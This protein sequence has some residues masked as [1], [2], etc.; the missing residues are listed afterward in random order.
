MHVKTKTVPGFV[1]EFTRV[2]PIYSDYILVDDL[3]DQTGAYS[4][5]R[6]EWNQDVSVR[7]AKMRY[8]LKGF[9]FFPVKVSLD[10]VISKLPNFLVRPL[11]DVIPIKR[12]LEESEDTTWRNAHPFDDLRTRLLDDVDF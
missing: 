5:Y 4:G 3:I 10:D 1:Y 6:V 11:R 8:Y 12:E 2:N 9:L 7:P